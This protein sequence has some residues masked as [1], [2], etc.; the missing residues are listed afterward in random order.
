M[1]RQQRAMQPALRSTPPRLR[2]L[3]P[4]IPIAALTVALPLVDRVEPR[5]AGIPFV[6]CWIVGWALA[7]PVFLWITGR[8]EKRW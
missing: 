8:I 4:G 7:A 5:I 6:L 3:L 2:F 1:H